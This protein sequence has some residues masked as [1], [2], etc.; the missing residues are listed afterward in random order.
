M[1]KLEK[2][3]KAIALSLG[4]AVMTLS[5]TNLNAQI[6]RGLLDNPYKDQSNKNHGMI[7]RDGGSGT[8]VNGGFTL[9]SGTQ[10][11]PTS[12]LGNGIS[13]FLALGAGYV[14]SKKKEEKR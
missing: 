6:N 11:D 1:E 3:R 12:P 4:L 7:N 5:A 10:E 2:K 14:A 8:N 9:G 13:I